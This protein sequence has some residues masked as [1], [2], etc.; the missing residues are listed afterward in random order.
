MFLQTEFKETKITHYA[1]LP[2]TNAILHHQHILTAVCF[3]PSAQHHP[4]TNTSPDFYKLFQV[5]LHYFYD[6]YR[7]I[8]G[9]AE[10]GR[11]GS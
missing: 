3:H 1:N 5:F 7:R 8:S 10:A 2:R 4:A 6:I 11:W 9:T